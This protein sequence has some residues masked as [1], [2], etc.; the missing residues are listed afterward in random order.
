MAGLINLIVENIISTVIKSS[1]KLVTTSIEHSYKKEI[2]A[3]KFEYDQ[4]LEN[5]K[6]KNAISLNKEI[7]DR[8]HI[9]RLKEQRDYFLC[10]KGEK[11]YEHFLKYSWP[12]IS[13]PD[14]LLRILR[15]NSNPNQIP[16]LIIFAGYSPE[17]ANLFDSAIN[18][19]DEILT[20]NNGS[21]SSQ[22][23]RTILYKG[24]WRMDGNF[25]QANGTPYILNLF[26]ALKGYPTLVF[27]PIYYKCDNKVSINIYFW[28]LGSIDYLI[29][30]NVFEI[31]VPNTLNNF[32]DESL[33][34][35][36]ITAGLSTIS[37]AV[38][39][40]YYF[41]EYNRIPQFRLL[42]EQKN[43]FDVNSL[44]YHGILPNKEIFLNWSNLNN[45]N[46]L[47]FAPEVGASFLYECAYCENFK[48]Q[49]WIIEA[50]NNIFNGK[51]SYRYLFDDVSKRDILYNE[52]N[53]NYQLLS[54]LSKLAWRCKLEKDSD[55]TKAWDFFCENSTIIL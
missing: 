41:L 10:L 18:K 16:L 36:K 21:L 3:K 2:E 55:I 46:N 11:E 19:L 26:E 17:I 8:T 23:Q 50:A 40:M 24:G 42:L 9:T 39:D 13:P 32:V 30:K 27:E 35:S 14:V 5:L 12:L 25:G 15:T 4:F 29:N 44:E 48:C 38:S 31:S 33:L 51:V 22:E 6:S 43:F 52:L 7:I 1:A 34:V 49:P 45:G 54:I 28:S 53:M 20:L 47:I 37:V